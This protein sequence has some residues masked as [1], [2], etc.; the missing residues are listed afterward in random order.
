MI[1]V[2]LGLASVWHLLHPL[3]NVGNKT[4]NGMR[5]VTVHCTLLALAVYLLAKANSVTSLL[6]GLLTAVMLWSLRLRVFAKG[7]A[8]IHIFVL[9]I[10]AI[11]LV[12]VFAPPS[13][14]VFEA[15]GR[16]STLTDRTIIWAWVLRLMPN[17]WIG[18]GYSSFWLGPRLETMIVNVTHTWAPNQAH[19]GYLEIFLNL[20]WVGVGLLGLVIFKGYCDVI[21][22]W[23]EKRPAS[24]LMLAY[25]L[26]GVISNI[27]EASFFR[28]LNSGWLFFLIAITSSKV[29]AS[30]SAAYVSNRHGARSPARS[31]DLAGVEASWSPQP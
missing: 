12:A 10:I 14:D 18:A 4:H 20:G 29:T 5:H 6:C 22:A 30:R 13:P 7:R 1:S 9:A 2:H 19:N 26:I 24:D 23:R 8:L 21:A 15:V 3:A 25:F 11:P 31:A 27:S 16:N 17:D 28:N